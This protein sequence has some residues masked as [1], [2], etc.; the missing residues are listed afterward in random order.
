[1]LSI[2]CPSRIV[3]L[4]VIVVPGRGGGVMA[5]NITGPIVRVG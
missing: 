5:I 3:V 1:M 2:G 4:V